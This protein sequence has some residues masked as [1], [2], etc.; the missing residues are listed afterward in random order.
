MLYLFFCF[1]Q[2][3]ITRINSFL[4]F[5]LLIEQTT[6]FLKGR[7]LTLNELHIKIL[8]LQTITVLNGIVQLSMNSL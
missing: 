1:L 6:D 5:L 2:L 7:H 8:I 4:G 3:S